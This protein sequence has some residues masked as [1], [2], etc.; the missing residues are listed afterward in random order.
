M[1]RTPPPVAARLSALET[2]PMPGYRVSGSLRLAIASALA[3]LASLSSP[4]QAQDPRNA[5]AP[6]A[7][8]GS[9][10]FNLQVKSNLVVVRVLVRDAQGKP[11]DGL[12]KEDFRVLDSGKEQSIAQFESR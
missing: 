9:T 12:R 4:L 11:V 7:A 5:Q 2:L 1:I 6:T 8:E 10:P 3:L